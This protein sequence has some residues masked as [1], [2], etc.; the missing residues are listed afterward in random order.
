LRLLITGGKGQVGRALEYET[1]K[2]GHQVFALGRDRL[3]LEDPK[4]IRKVVSEIAPDWVL[5]CAAATK[6]DRCEEDRD[7]AMTLNAKAPGW[8]A[9]TCADEGASLLHWST[10][11][12]FDGKG[13]VPLD[14][15]S[16]KN[17]L[18]CYGETKALGE[19]AVL[20]VEPGSSLIL[21]TQW[22]YG[23]KGRNF[24]AA[25]L[26]RARTGQGLKVVDDQT[27]R[28]SYSKDLA[29]GALDLIE[30]GAKGIFH[31]AG[32]SMAT[33]FQFAKSLLELSGF[34]DIPIEPCGSDAFPLPA[35]RPHFSV[36]ALDKVE[37]FLGRKMPP[38]EK[39]LK[40]WLEQEDAGTITDQE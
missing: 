33:W 40:D 38:L 26:A 34:Q 27:G 1:E 16:P 11:F 22:V 9:E 8:L 7:W 18:S 31:L 19:E 23:P 29:V 10:D 2:R 20:S 17:P 13:K 12:V 28:P 5:N 3:D 36:L 37:T 4:S 25:I 39:G 21:R 35:E 15:D 32:G 14:E 30:G 24:P 6:V